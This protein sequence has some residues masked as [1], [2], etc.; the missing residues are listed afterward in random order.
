M[1]QEILFVSVLLVIFLTG[2][3][4]YVRY[5]TIEKEDC[6]FIGYP[7]KGLVLVFSWHSEWGKMPLLLEKRGYKKDDLT[8]I[9][10]GD[11][12]SVL[13]K[14]SVEPE[15][16]EK[17]ENEKV[18]KIYRYYPSENS[19]DATCACPYNIS[20]LYVDL[21]IK[22]SKIEIIKMKFKFYR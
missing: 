22:D 11:S 6:V 14:I 7:E 15:I 19:F 1:K 21:Y 13:D 20:V 9:L 16:L 10:V 2:C 8:F 18:H 12:V 3:K 4:E 17:E 5:D